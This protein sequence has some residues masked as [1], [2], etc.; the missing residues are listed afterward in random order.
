MEKKTSS[1]GVKREKWISINILLLYTNEAYYRF[2]KRSLMMLSL[3]N[4]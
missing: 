4:F 3:K 2:S 1:E